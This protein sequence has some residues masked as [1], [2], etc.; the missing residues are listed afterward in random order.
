MSSKFTPP[1]AGAMLKPPTDVQS[2]YRRQ[3]FARAPC[4]GASF[5]A[6]KECQFGWSASGNDVFVPQESRLVMKLAVRSNVQAN[7]EAIAGSIPATHDRPPSKNVRFATNAIGQAFSSGRVSVG[8]GGS[9]TVETIGADL[10]DH[11]LLQLRLEG[12]KAGAEAGGSAGTLSFNQTM[13]HPAVAAAGGDATTLSYSSP[14]VRSDKHTLIQTSEG[15]EIEL[16][17]PLGILFRFFAQQKSYLRNMDF[18]MRLVVSATAAADMLYTQLIEPQ[19]RSRGLPV[20]A[21]GVADAHKVAATLLPALVAVANGSHAVMCTDLF[22][23]AMFCTPAS[24]LPPLRSA[25]IPFTGIT[26][27]TRPLSQNQTSHVETISGLPPSTTLICIASRV[28]THTLSSNRELFAAGGGPSGIKSA[29]LT[30]GVISQPS[31]SYDLDFQERRCARAFADAAS[32]TG[33]DYTDGSG[34]QSLTEYCDSPVLCLRVLQPKHTY[35]PTATLR[36]ELKAGA[37]ENQQLLVWCVHSRVFEATWP[38]DNAT[39]PNSVVVE[40][41]IS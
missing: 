41:L 13:M 31:P 2:Y 3:L 29:L 19:A 8:S 15:R 38:S 6:G 27:F 10:A 7:G 40:E 24:I 14:G 18:D 25:Q 20:A 17:V 1:P 16:S 11:G 21:E 37:L 32:V 5:V 33:S 35:V 22:I 39:Q 12:T 36:I 28:N 34:A 9:T 26:M 30:A 4:T 23:D